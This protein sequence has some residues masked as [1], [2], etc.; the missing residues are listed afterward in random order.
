M[1]SVFGGSQQEMHP[2]NSKQEVGYLGQHEKILEIGYKNHMLFQEGSNV[3]L[4][5][6]PQERVATKFS[7]YDET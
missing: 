5:M 7:R 1:N 4:W 6:A 2:T 3:P